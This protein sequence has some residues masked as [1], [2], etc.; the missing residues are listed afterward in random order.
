MVDSVGDE[1]KGVK[2][3][4]ATQPTT[5]DESLSLD[6]AEKR[7]SPSPTPA[8]SRGFFERLNEKVLSIKFLEQR[9]IERVTEEER[10]GI[11]GAKYMQMLLLWF[12]T[13]ITANNI[14][15]GMLGP[16]S[17][18]L[19]FT[20][21]ALCAAF[22]ALLGS[23]G[24][25]YMSTFGPES[26]NRTM[27]IARYFM[28]YYPSKIAC[29][30]NIVIMLGYG[31]IDCL[32]GGQILSAVSGGN[33]SVVAGIIIV[34]A[35]TW[36][37]TVF[38]MSIFQKYERWAWAPQLVAI[39]VLVGSAGPTF[40][41]SITSVGNKETIN[42]NRLSF[43]SLCLSSAVA[44]A[45]AAADYYVYYPPT[46]Q[47]WKTFTMTIC[48]IALA[49]AFANLLGVGLASGT[50]SNTSWL[51]AYDTSSGALI[52]AGYAGLGG[53][54]KFLGVIVAF[55]LI[56]NNIPG[57]YSATLGFQI[58]GRQ[59][60]K[61]PRWFLSCV[62]V[63]VYTACALGGR[64]HLFDIFENFLALMGYWVT[65]Y[66]T[67]VLEEH[68]IFRRTS[69][70]DWTAWKD[71]SKLPIGIA[72]L[73]AFLIGWAGSIISM[74]QIWYVGPIAKMV[75]EYGT[76]LGIWVGVS[77]AMIVFPPL[78]WLELKKVGR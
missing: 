26:G 53:F 42:G 75:G 45:P 28:G 48:G 3:D 57:T 33:I 69:G 17:Y 63:V 77:W 73:A 29:L 1:E 30:L 43:F 41:T 19:G 47:K 6:D 12:S 66:L 21:S 16:L 10:H 76:D 62:C 72:A 36:V 74:Y 2:R 38:G 27:V 35:I 44:W 58:M 8:T 11:T 7:T 22:G 56:A 60:A 50:F 15:V 37:V 59:L 4:I 5:A 78:R 14:A 39:F 70:F 40:D 64:N 68:L 67:I 61:L 34:A 18:D 52:M 51:D 23:A 65:I 71:R 49:L 55:G 20:D 31:M 13:N 32:I 25:A 9:G 46:T 24:A 54:G